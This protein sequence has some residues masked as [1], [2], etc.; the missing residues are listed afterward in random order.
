MS[1][2]NLLIITIIATILVLIAIYFTKG[3]KIFTKIIKLSLKYL[4][5]ILCVLAQQIYL[6]EGEAKKKFVVN[7]I[8]ALITKIFIKLKIPVKKIDDF[9]ILNFGT[10]Y[11]ENIVQEIYDDNLSK[12]TKVKQDLV[13]QIKEDELYQNVKKSIEEFN[14]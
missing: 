12:I 14:E 4:I 9:L 7:T 5:Y 6:S 11:I 13:A 10:T 3:N 1:T 8:K 2:I